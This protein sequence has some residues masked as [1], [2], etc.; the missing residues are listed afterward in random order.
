M[1][2]YRMDGWMDRDPMRP[3]FV[4]TTDE[5]ERSILAVAACLPLPPASATA[6]AATTAAAKTAVVSRSCAPYWHRYS[7]PTQDSS[8]SR[9]LLSVIATAVLDVTAVL[10]FC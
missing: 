6:T 3:S 2:E 5:D 10:C 1:E 4:S 7:E 9:W 8:L